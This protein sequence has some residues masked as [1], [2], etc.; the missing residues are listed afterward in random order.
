MYNLKEILGYCLIIMSLFDAWKY[1]WQAQAIKRIKVAKGH[2][3][4]FINVAICNDIFKLSYG[5]CIKDNFIVLSSLCALI[6]M[7]YNFYILYL[8]YPYRMRG[9]INFRRPNILMYLT[10]SIL[11]NRLRK[12]L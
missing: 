1:I 11:P 9:M 10:N 6:T 7:A 4:K 12:R 8:Y 3:R 2:S 5:A